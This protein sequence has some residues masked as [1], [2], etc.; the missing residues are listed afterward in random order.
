MVEIS[1]IN[2]DLYNF[3]TLFLNSSDISCLLNIISH[4]S[5]DE[6]KDLFVQSGVSPTYLYNITGAISV[7]KTTAIARLQGM[8]IIDEWLSPREQLIA[9]STEQLNEKERETVDRWVLDQVRL[10][11]RR[12]IDANVGLHVMDRAPLDPFAFVEKDNFEVKARQIYDIACAG[13]KREPQK[14]K[15]AFV[16]LLL[17]DPKQLH[18]RQKWRGRAGGI[19]YIKKQQEALESIYCPNGEVAVI[20]TNNK[21]I[22]EVVKE[23]SRAIHCREY[24]PYK[25]HE[26][27]QDLG[28]NL[29]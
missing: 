19:D 28:K 5:D 17:G 2:F 29:F 22:A 14:F 20:Q 3:V 1:R 8:T 6:F 25:L 15:E 9:K 4:K 18:M 7:G 13:D 11:N 12:F 27:L 23:V 16:I 10:K 21:S 26:R 24:R